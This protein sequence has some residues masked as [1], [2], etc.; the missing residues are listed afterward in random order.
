MWKRQKMVRWNSVRNKAAGALL[1]KAEYAEEGDELSIPY[2][3]FI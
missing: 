3:N 1:K 2:L